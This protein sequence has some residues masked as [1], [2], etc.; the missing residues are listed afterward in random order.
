MITG[1]ALNQKNKNQTL[2]MNE[3]KN[4]P[5]HYKSERASKGSGKPGISPGRSP[6]A[7]A[8]EQS[9]QR[10]ESR[11]RCSVLAQSLADNGKKKKIQLPKSN[12]VDVW[13]PNAV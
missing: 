2:R 12:N 1:K 4:D 11:K 6:T 9:T 13:N 5:N 8:R 10:R 3:L 7:Q